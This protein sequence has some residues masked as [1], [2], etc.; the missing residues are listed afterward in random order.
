MFHPVQA[1][2]K[3]FTIIQTE[4]LKVYIYDYEG[5]VYINIHFKLKDGSTQLRT[6]CSFVC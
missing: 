5:N 4:V 1:T 3:E 6:R 2:I